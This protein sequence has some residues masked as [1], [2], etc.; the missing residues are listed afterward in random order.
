MQ[1]FE[2]KLFD[3][4]ISYNIELNINTGFQLKSEGSTNRCCQALYQKTLVF[5]AQRI[6]RSV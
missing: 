5:S 3:S 2:I 6:S 4:V 1:K